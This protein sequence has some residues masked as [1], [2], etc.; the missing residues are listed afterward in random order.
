MNNY[1]YHFL[2]FH[3]GGK[4]REAA[5][6]LSNSL[7]QFGIR[8][9]VIRIPDQGAWNK[10][11]NCKAEI[12]YSWYL[13]NKKPFVVL[14]ADC[15]V[16]KEPVVFQ[17]RLTDVA[18]MYCKKKSFYISTGVC[19]FD[20]NDK[21]KLLLEHW[22]M[23]SSYARERYPDNLQLWKS[24]LALKRA[25]KNPLVTRSGIQ[26]KELPKTY[27]KPYWVEWENI[28]TKDMNN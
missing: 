10:N 27:G 17:N 18:H 26:K 1:Y 16:H 25:W 2:T 7:K 28:K 8:L 20:Y 11:T 3:T 19:A 13:N 15:V 12:L 5:K 6:R 4:Y 24:D 14:D 9:N 23:Y 21:V 22:K